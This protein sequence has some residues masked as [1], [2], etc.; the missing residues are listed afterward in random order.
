MSTSKPA[1]AAFLG[2]VDEVRAGDGAEL[3]ADEDGRALGVTFN[4]A[5]FRADQFAGPGRERGEADLVVLVAPAA[6]AVFSVSRMMA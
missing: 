4:V 3:G 5:A 1:S 6:P 2:G